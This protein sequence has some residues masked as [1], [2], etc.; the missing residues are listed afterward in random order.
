MLHS[1]SH[2]CVRE[3]RGRPGLTGWR[4][5]AF[6]GGRAYVPSSHS[7]FPPLTLD[8]LGELRS[9]GCAK[10]EKHGEDADPPESTTHLEEP[11][12]FAKIKGLLRSRDPAGRE[13][14][15]QYLTIACERG[16]WSF[17]A[18]P[19]AILSDWASALRLACGPNSAD[20]IRVREA[21]LV[22]RLSLTLWSN[23]GSA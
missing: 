3:L 22:S 9:T 19:F 8:F 5:F 2:F 14:P 10:P 21:A 15:C 12:Q 13:T 7:S 18:V 11:L 4:R 6:S 16:L 23:I 1:G 20:S 17:G